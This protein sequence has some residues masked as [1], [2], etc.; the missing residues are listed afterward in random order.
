[1]GSFR[2]PFFII[3]DDVS[4]ASSLE[5]ALRCIEPWDVPSVRLYDS[6]GTWIP[7]KARD[8]QVTK[9]TVGSGHTELDQA[10]Q[11]VSEPDALYDALLAYWL[12]LRVRADVSRLPAMASVPS[13][14]E[15]THVIASLQLDWK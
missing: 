9:H 4:V 1:M 3:D 12:V 11:P 14:A 6:E 13:L 10:M 15:L 2:P 5:N 7:L 8:V